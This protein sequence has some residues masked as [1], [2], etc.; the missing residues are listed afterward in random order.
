MWYV[1]FDCEDGDKFRVS[2]RRQPLY[3]LLDLL[4]FLPSLSGCIILGFEGDNVKFKWRRRN[5]VIYNR[6]CC[7]DYPETGS[8]KENQ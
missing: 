2:N 3:F 1:K 8:S 6:I 7:V 4:Q 5:N